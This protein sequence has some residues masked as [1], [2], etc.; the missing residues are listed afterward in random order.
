MTRVIVK[1]IVVL[2]LVY[3]LLGGMMMSHAAPVANSP[4]HPLLACGG[5]VYLPP[6]W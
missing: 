5:E 3:T 2:G 6:C 4:A 1:T